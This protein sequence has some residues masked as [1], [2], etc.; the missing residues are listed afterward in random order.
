MWQMGILPNVGVKTTISRP[1]PQPR[2]SLTTNASAQDPET[3]WAASTCRLMKDGSVRMPCHRLETQ[4]Q[5][6][7]SHVGSFSS[8]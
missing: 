5:R 7:T 6:P 1:M 2:F 3:M 8:V 4:R